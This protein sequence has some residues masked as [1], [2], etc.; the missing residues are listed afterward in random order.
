MW[1]YL[2]GKEGEEIG[3]LLVLRTVRLL[4]YLVEVLTLLLDVNKQRVSEMGK[5]RSV[6]NAELFY[7]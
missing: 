4:Q 5:E 1:I 7:E 2:L 3:S 6:K